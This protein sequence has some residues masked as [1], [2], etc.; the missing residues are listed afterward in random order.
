ML[1]APIDDTVEV[2]D[3]DELECVQPEDTEDFAE[4][5]EFIKNVTDFHEKLSTI[6]NEIR[7]T[8]NVYAF[9]EE[10]CTKMSKFSDELNNE[11]SQTKLNEIIEQYKVD[12]KFEEK[13]E[14]LEKLKKEY[15]L[16]LKVQSRLRWKPP[17]SFKCFVCLE[18]VVD[19]FINPCGHTMCSDCWVKHDA[20]PRAHRCPG[21]RATVE[22]A[23]RLFFLN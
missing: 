12:F 22:N 18:R 6:K 19:T 21:C 3:T 10:T 15:S 11:I 4:Y 23:R 9:I 13:K 7:R 8:E 20:G 2:I 1:G 17:A 16:M 5:T 14:T